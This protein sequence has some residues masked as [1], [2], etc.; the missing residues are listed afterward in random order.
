MRKTTPRT[1][2]RIQNV[3]EER[4]RL[5][6]E[7]EQK[8]DE[9]NDNVKKAETSARDLNLRLG[10]WYF[11]V[12]EEVYSKIRLRKSQVLKEKEPEEPEEGTGIDAF[13]ALQET[14]PAIDE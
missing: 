12:D 14:G 5:I 11:V 10:D 2:M 3:D 4:D 7:Y 6:K 1:M 8:L 13:R 9:Y